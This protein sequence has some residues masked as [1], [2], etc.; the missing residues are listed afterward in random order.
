MSRVAGAG[1][2]QTTGVSVL[3]WVFCFPGLDADSEGDDTGLVI[4]VVF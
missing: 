2:H 1:S 4:L 3:D